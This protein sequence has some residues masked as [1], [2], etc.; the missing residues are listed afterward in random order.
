MKRIEWPES[1][2]DRGSVRRFDDVK[3]YPAARSG[4]VYARQIATFL[5]YA[6][7][8]VLKYPMLQGADGKKLPDWWQVD[9]YGSQYCTE[10]EAMQIVERIR[11]HR[12][13]NPRRKATPPTMTAPERSSR[14]RALARLRQNSEQMLRSF[15]VVTPGH[16][17]KFLA[18]L[19]GTELGELDVDA[20]LRAEGIR[21]VSLDNP[22]RWTMDGQAVEPKKFLAL[23]PSDITPAIRA[24]KAAAEKPARRIDEAERA[25]RATVVWLPAK[26][27]GW[28]HPDRARTVYPPGI[29]RLAL[30]RSERKT[31]PG[32]AILR[33]W[34]T[35]LHLV[36]EINGCEV[37]FAFVPAK[38]RYHALLDPEDVEEILL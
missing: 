19:D 34:G 7:E 23:H 8:R 20:V 10:D 31:E 38:G 35:D 15:C 37:D 1:W 24:L 2:N 27:N 13:T 6:I 26:P 9:R 21:L 28:Q 36:E 16:D 17:A 5:D 22:E 14:E 18:K 12:A 3:N 29:E 30:D 4:I 25:E 33:G 32:W 11:F